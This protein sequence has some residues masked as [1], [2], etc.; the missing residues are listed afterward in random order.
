MHSPLQGCGKPQT[1]DA[2]A[3]PKE[4]KNGGV[5]GHYKKAGGVKERKEEDGSGGRE[6]KEKSYR[7]QKRNRALPAKKKCRDKYLKP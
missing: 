6:R 3:R 5:Q 7:K 2:S 4:R 1:P